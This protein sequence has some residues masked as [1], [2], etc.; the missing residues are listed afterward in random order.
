MRTIQG[1]KAQEWVEFY[2]PLLYLLSS[3]ADT[4]NYTVTCRKK[5][6]RDRFIVLLKILHFYAFCILLVNIFYLRQQNLIS[7]GS[8]KF[9]AYN[10]GGLS[11]SLL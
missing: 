11:I 1:L 2:A 4:Q 3:T 5:N 8:S 6:S 10:L 9:K 7:V